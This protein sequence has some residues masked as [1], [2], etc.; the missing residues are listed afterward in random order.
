MQTRFKME[1]MLKLIEIAEEQNKTIEYVREISFSLLGD[2]LKTIENNPELQLKITNA[3]SQ[4]EI[5]TRPNVK[6]LEI[7][8]TERGF[9]TPTR[10]KHNEYMRGVKSKYNARQRIKDGRAYSDGLPLEELNN[11]N[12]DLSPNDEV[13]ILREIEEQE[14]NSPINIDKNTNTNTN[15]NK[16]KKSKSNT[17]TLEELRAKFGENYNPTPPLITGFGKG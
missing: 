14:Q 5:T 2:A 3:L 1:R 16:N 13:P 10:I 8:L 17:E 9:Y 12:P 4:I 6:H 15:T 7:I 11:Y